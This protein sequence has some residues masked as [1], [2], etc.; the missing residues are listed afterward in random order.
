MFYLKHSTLFIQFQP[1]VQFKSL[2]KKGE[3]R[4]I[5]GSHLLGLCCDDDKL[6]TVEAGG[7]YALCMYELQGTVIVRR[8]DRVSLPEERYMQ[9][10]HPRVDRRTHRVYIPCLSHGVLI[11]RCVNLFLRKT[12]QL[13]CMGRAHSVTMHSPGIVVVCDVEYNVVYLV[14]IANDRI[15][16]I[17]KPSQ[18]VNEVPLYASVLGESL[19]VSYGD[20]TLVLYASGGSSPGRVLATP[21]GLVEVFSI[22]TDNYSSFLVTNNER[23]DGS[24]FILDVRGNCRHEIQQHIPELRDCVV[25]QS[26]LWLAGSKGFIQFMASE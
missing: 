8:L 14:D 20:N 22:T 3:T 16:K 15:L 10:C 2:K 5:W 26:Q 21:D 9:Y 25:I 19:L 4:E 12:G 7:G 13:T 6:Y 23:G 24:V 18:A 17:L 11:F 1:P